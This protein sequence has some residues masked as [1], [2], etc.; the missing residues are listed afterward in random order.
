MAKLFTIHY[1]LFTKNRVS[2]LC[3]RDVEGAEGG[4]KWSVSGTKHGSE[5][6]PGTSPTA[7]ADRGRGKP[8][9]PKKMKNEK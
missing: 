1:S 9:C 3:I 8:E 2:G 7:R 4:A 5:A 6:D